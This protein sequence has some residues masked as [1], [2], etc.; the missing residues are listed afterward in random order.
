MNLF[1]LSSSS[2]Y[3]VAIVDMD[4]DFDVS[5]VN[6]KDI[7]YDGRAYSRQVEWVEGS[8]YVWIGGRQDDEAYVIDLS[9]KKLIKTFTDVDPRKLLSVAPH[10]FM[11]MADEYNNY[12]QEN[13]ALQGSSSAMRFGSNG[14]GGSNNILSIAALAISI[15]AIA[16]VIGSFFAAKKSSP[17]SGGSAKQE[18]PMAV[19]V[20][21]SKVDDPS[22]AV[23]PSV[24]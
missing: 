11:G 23:P 7:P 1:V 19:S 3:Q 9:T 24:A 16:A 14:D 10:H 6:L 21:G 4:N 2:D 13:G 22:L 8:N 5:Y 20:A 17:S 15:V 12:F 18:S